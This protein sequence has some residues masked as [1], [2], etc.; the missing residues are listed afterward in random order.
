MAEEL[1]AEFVDALAVRGL[2]HLQPIDELLDDAP[3]EPARVRGGLVV[4]VTTPPFGVL[5]DLDD[6][7]HVAGRYTELKFNP[8]GAIEGAAV[9]EYLLE[10]SRVVGQAPGE[11]NFHVFYYAFAGADAE[12]HGLDMEELAFVIET[13]VPTMRATLEREGIASFSMDCAIAIYLYTIDE[14]K[15]YKIV[16]TACHAAD[17]DDT[18]DEAI[19]RVRA[20]VLSGL[21]SDQTSPRSLAGRAKH[22]VV[23]QRMVSE[24]MDARLNPVGSYE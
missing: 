14:P 15:L 19:E 9:S 16:N 5:V 4:L 12:A 11:R 21:R 1:G 6:P 24:P 17:R 18:T 7:D 13:R 3:G 8:R 20:Q 23:F 10:K 2:V 22:S